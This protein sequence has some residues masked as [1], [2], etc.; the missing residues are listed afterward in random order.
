MPA[1]RYRARHSHAI[2]VAIILAS[3]AVF[4]PTMWV[5][6]ESPAASLPEFPAATSPGVTARPAGSTATPAPASPRPTLQPTAP[7]VV[8][9][10]GSSGGS[11]LTPLALAVLL[12][13]VLIAGALFFGLRRRPAA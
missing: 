8:N 3:L 11:D 7:G 13:G 9:P 5:R 4:A 6:G 10:D 1:R 2:A 12:V